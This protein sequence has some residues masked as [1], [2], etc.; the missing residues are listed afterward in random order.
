MWPPRKRHVQYCGDSRLEMNVA[1]RETT[2]VDAHAKILLKSDC[3]FFE[4]ILK[5]GL[6]AIIER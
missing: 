6:D 5:I 3:V 4:K 1:I 2:Y